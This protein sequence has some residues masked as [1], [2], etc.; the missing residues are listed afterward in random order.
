MKILFVSTEFEEQA[1]GITGIIKA[2]VTAAKA[3]GH[4]VG[5][6]AGYPY[7]RQREGELLND[8]VEHIYL[9]HYLETGK[10]HIFPTGLRGKKNQLKIITKRDYLKANEV[11]VNHDLI[12][13]PTSLANKLDFVVRIPYVYH[14][15]NHGLGS[16][17]KRTI[18][19]AIKK[20]NID[21]VITGAPMDITQ[22]EVAPAR[23]IQF[24][25]DTMPLDM[26]ETPADNQTP[27]KFARQLYSAAHG[28]NMVFTNSEDTAQKVFE[29]NPSAAVQIL[30]G[31]ASNK[32][33]QF[34][35]TTYLVR[36]G[37]EK[38]KF[39]L[40]ISVIE[41]R[42]NIA[43][44]LDAYTRAYDKLTM[45]LVIVGGKG[46]GYKDI[47]AHYNDLP[48]H[49]QKNVIFTG[50]IS[51]SDKYTLLNN[52]RAFVFPSLYEGIGLPIIEAFASN[53][54]VLTSRRGALPEAGGEAA[55]YIEDPY[56]TDEIAAGL[57]KITHDETLRETLRSH[58]DEQSKKFTPEK[59]NARFKKAIDSLQ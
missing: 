44:L 26:L 4:E 25:H 43:T 1:R 55:F 57:I 31:I 52:A 16:I 46:F 39:L 8:K 6:L 18:K 19:K 14:F 33:S 45:P 38:D 53:L 37:L 24:V 35:D 22:K 10:Y 42:K 7:I 34:K 51:E 21:L 11:R 47:M 23:L 17:S 48:D 54:P 27:E 49:I 56:D 29:I 3:E 15:I 59:F 50:F 40:F 5:I 2:M 58:M 12:Q 32:A 30:Y 13:R 41:R 20:Y 9:Q 28:S 36:K